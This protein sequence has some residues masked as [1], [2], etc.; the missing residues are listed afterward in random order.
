MFKGLPACSFQ[1]TESAVEV[2][3]MREE[4]EEWE[5]EEEEEWEE[6]EW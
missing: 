1:N 6:E 2:K 4:E 3:N 5:E